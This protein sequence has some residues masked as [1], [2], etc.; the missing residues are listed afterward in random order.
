MT[1]F[2]RIHSLLFWVGSF[3]YFKQKRNHREKLI[4]DRILSQDVLFGSFLF[5]ATAFFSRFRND[6]EM[7]WYSQ[8]QYHCVNRHRHHHVA[9]PYGTSDWSWNQQSV[10]CLGPLSTTIKPSLVA[11]YYSLTDQSANEALVQSVA[12]HFPQRKVQD[13]SNMGGKNV[14]QDQSQIR[15]EAGSFNRETTGSWTHLNKTSWWTDRVKITVV[16]GHHPVSSHEGAP[17]P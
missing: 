1:P 15:G 8:L 12:Q 16:P 14:N 17:P 5:Q 9:R 7:H 2:C 13:L 10:S 11:F 6:W 3:F 4:A